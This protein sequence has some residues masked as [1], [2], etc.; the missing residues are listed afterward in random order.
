[1]TKSSGGK[2]RQLCNNWADY[3]DKDSL[4]PVDFAGPVSMAPNNQLSSIDCQIKTHPY[5]V[6]EP[7][8]SNRPPSG[9]SSRGLLPAQSNPTHPTD[10]LDETLGRHRPFV[11]DLA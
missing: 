2:A 3:T 6:R 10:D 7:K 5:R 4:F 1:M 11:E 9:T 8:L